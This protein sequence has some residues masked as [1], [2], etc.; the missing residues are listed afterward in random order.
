MKKVLSNLYSLVII[1]LVIWMVLSVLNI[2]FQSTMP[3][4]VIADWNL[5]IMLLK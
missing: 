1:L 4:H 3:D 2:S 5:F